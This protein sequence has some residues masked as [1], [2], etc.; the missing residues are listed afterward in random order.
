[1][2][3]VNAPKLHA[4][5]VVA[6]MI[7]FSSPASGA[8]GVPVAPGG[9]TV[10]LDREYSDTLLRGSF[11]LDWSVVQESGDRFVYEIRGF[12]DSRTCPL[13]DLRDIDCGGFA[14][15]PSRVTVYRSAWDG[16][17]SGHLAQNRAVAVDMESETAPFSNGTM[18]GVVVVPSAGVEARKKPVFAWY[19]SRTGISVSMAFRDVSGDGLEDLVYTYRQTMPGGVSVMPCDVWTFV[20]MVAARY[21]SS[22]EKLS[23]VSTSTFEGVP[24]VLDAD[25]RHET[26]LFAFGQVPVTM[27]DG[28]RGTVQVLSVERGVFRDGQPPSWEMQVLADTGTGW[29]DYLSTMGTPCDTGAEGGAGAPEGAWNADADRCSFSELPPDAP[30][31]IRRS[32]IDMEGVCR[33]AVSPVE[34]DAPLLRAAAMIFR[35]MVLALGGHPVISAVFLE[36]AAIELDTVGLRSFPLS[37]AAAVQASAAEEAVCGIRRDIVCL[38]SPVARPRGLMSDWLVELPG[39]TDAVSRMFFDWFER[40]ALVD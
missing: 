19:L 28:G 11:G 35:G 1:M 36:S 21:V 12:V 31:E 30:I 9:H 22:G 2:L 3:L 29:F 13:Q 16:A 18:H 23:G 17:L 26:G 20:D 33:F 40:V 34:F 25:G 4:L 39:F 14:W 10:D 8:T 6:A 32:F 15:V 5:T 24:L 38:N 37:F 27:P 7:A